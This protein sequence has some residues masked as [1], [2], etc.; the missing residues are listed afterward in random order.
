[1]KRL[2][3]VWPVISILLISLTMLYARDIMAPVA[4]PVA[5]ESIVGAGFSPD[6]SR[7]AVV[8]NATVRGTSN[9]R[10][11]LQVVDLN[12]RRVVR[13]ADVLKTE[14]VDLANN[15]HWI[16]YS[17][18]GRYLLLAT[19]GSDVL[20]ILDATSLQIL[21]RIALHPSADLRR[22]L[23]GERH[24]F[25]GVVS[26]SRSSRG[27]LFGVLT[28]D[29]LDGNEV[30]I[31]SYSSREIKQHWELGSRRTAT[32]LGETG[33]SLNDDGTELVVSVLPD[34]NSLP[35]PFRNLRLYRSAT[36]QLL[37]SIRTDGLVGK[38]ILLPGEEVL[39]SRI[40][41][42]GLFSRKTCIE[43]WNLNTGALNHRFCDKTGNV[44]VALAAS[45]GKDRVAGFAARMHKDIEGIVYAA[46]GRVDVWNADS[47]DLIA[48]SG[49]FPRLISSL[50][51]APNGQFVMANGALMQIDHERPAES[52]SR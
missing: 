51:M 39:A 38:V 49:D 24:Y 1:M 50:Q 26:L 42:S 9:P 5:S 34:G 46:S 4:L 23:G 7:L 44:S 45:A 15:A 52:E 25:R 11:V 17:P 10:H 48:S 8:T 36:G 32:Q 13:E 14:P 31:C 47:G 33:L 20:S 43:K 2:T 37:K 21:S 30:F 27:D 35:K 3:L 22:L 16:S 12:S 28:H 40:D 29:E 19:Y 41:T 6:S 18:D